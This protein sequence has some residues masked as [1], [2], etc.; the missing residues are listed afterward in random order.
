MVSM[1][2]SDL[3]DSSGIQKTPQMRPR[4]PMAP[5]MKPTF[6]PS[7]A[8]SLSMY[9]S[10]KVTTNSKTVETMK[11]IMVDLSRSVMWL[12]S[13]LTTNRLRKQ[14]QLMLTESCAEFTYFAPND[15][16]YVVGNSIAI[17]MMPFLMPGLGLDTSPRPAI[18]K[19]VSVIKV[20]AT[21]NM[22][23]RPVLSTKKIT[24]NVPRQRRNRLIMVAVKALNVPILLMKI[25][26]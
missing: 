19:R 6:D 12:I 7:H 8:G 3:C 13:D 2:S 16:K 21:K 26:P 25:V 11:K 17:A 4:K 18:V 22:G 9:G 15:G 24:V 20:P 5:K 23:L 10:E 14:R 1:S